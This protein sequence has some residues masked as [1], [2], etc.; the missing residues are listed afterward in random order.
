MKRV[1]LLSL[2]LL[3]GVAG[4]AQTRV[5][6]NDIRKDVASMQK[7]VAGTEVLTPAEA[8]APQET[9]S[10]V[11]TR[12]H[13]EDVP[14]LIVTTYD[15][16]SNQFVANRMYQLPDGK[17]AATCTMS[18]QSNQTA[19]DR[20]TGYNFYDGSDWGAMPTARIESIK[21]GWPSIAQW[22]AN[23]EILLCHGGGHMQCYTREVAGQ[24]EWTPRNPLPD[25]PEGYPYAG[26]DDAYPTWPRVVTCGDNHNVILATAAIQHSISS[27]ESDTYIVFFRS[28]D[29]DN[30]EVSYGPLE[31]LGYHNGSF[32][33]DDYAMDANGHTVALL[34]SGSTK[35]SVWLFKST[36]DGLTWDARRVWQ[37]P[38]EGQDVVYTDTL[39]RP[40]NGAVAVGYDGTVH[41]VCNTFEMVIDQENID[42]GTFSYYY[43]RS[44]DG[45][46]YW[47]DQMDGP[48]ASED[49]NPH[50]AARL[51]WPDEENPGYVTMHADTT[52]WVGFI[53]MNI[54]PTTGSYISWENDKFY[55]AGTDY[56][57]RFYGAS[58]HPALSV[59]P[60]GNLAC[61][62]SS[63]NT[64]REDG[65]GTGHYFRSIY[66]S[67]LNVDEGY[68]HQLEEDITDQFMLA[69]SECIFTNTVSHVINPGEYWFSFM[70][71]EAV[72][73]YWGTNSAQTTATDNTIYMVKVDASEWTGVEEQAAKDVVYNI[74]PNP[75]T[76]VVYVESSMNANATVTFTNLA[77]QT[78]KSFSQSLINGVNTINIDL[79]SGVYFM[80]VNA[81]GFNKTTKVVVK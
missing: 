27:E 53:P 55:H 34:Y 59:D 3:I 23:G 57:Q 75:A 74:Y 32:S 52:K 28:T 18:H 29:A 69:E 5:M 41:V 43:G 19:S 42:E 63:P 78:V 64:A 36:D 62:F 46:F 16:Q 56:V 65:I 76:D 68:W 70:G 45:I 67:Y 15:L 11:S 72:G 44:V 21:T 25:Y 33:A 10:I 47:N 48:L 22:G 12:E 6:K 30:W 24:G 38:Y 81:N 51:W 17:M 40:M 2:G 66:V 4:F 8:F 39:F 73:M 13:D 77:G 61:A 71:D 80:T 35:N 49:G 20:G 1:F 7:T 14:E 60:Y 37:D 31:P 54:D 58:G 79:E 26:A 9:I 50:H